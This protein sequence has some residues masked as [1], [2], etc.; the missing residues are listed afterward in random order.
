LY[1]VER[2]REDFPILKSGVIYL[3]S[4]AS[5]LTPEPV[6]N[7]MI[8]YYHEYRANVE[9]GIYRLSQRASEEYEEAH[10]KVA[11]FINAKSD[12]E[13]VMTKNT[14]EGINLVAN[15]LA[16]KKGDKIVTTLIEHHSNFIVW[17]RVKQRFGV[18]VEVVKPNA[19][20]ILD[21]REFERAIDDKTRLVAVT[22]ISNVLGT[23]QPVEK[24]ARIAHDHGSLIL[25]DGAQSVPHLKTDVKSMGID[26]LAFSGHKMCGPTGSGALY[27]REEC[28]A[29]VEPLAIGGGT[30][31]DVGE[32]FYKLAES[33]RRYEAGTPSVAEAIGLGAATDYLRKLGMENIQTWERRLTE[34]AYRG[35]RQISGVDLYGPDPRHRIGILSFNVKG[36]NAHDVAL[37]LDTNANICVRSGH[38][39]A[40]P[41]AKAILRA[42][43]SVRASVYL[44]NT[45]E[46]VSKLVST[47]REIAGSLGTV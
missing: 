7:K 19:E 11:G 27:I 39:C 18:D 24:V 23:V 4:T 43:G 25:V 31:D 20:G 44:Y 14:T 22:H 3:D 30:I 1:D 36:L 40:L 26:F 29:Q 10:R 9:R 37:V 13:I 28:S 45:E 12:A 38:H 21:L 2:I 32:D 33:P 46:E 47:V 8:E 41:L 15:G 34:M 17:L 16:W 6:L 35:L 42:P 5:S